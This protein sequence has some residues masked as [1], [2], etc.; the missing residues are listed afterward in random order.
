MVATGEPLL[1]AEALVVGHGGRPILP[2]FDLEV[3]A[4]EL[5]VVIGRNGSGKTTLVRTLLG[6]LPPVAGRVRRLRSDLR[7]AHVPQ[8]LPFDPLFPLSAW[9]VVR[10]GTVRRGRALLVGH[11]ETDV[12]ARALEAVGADALARQSFGALSEGQRQRVL[13]ARALAG[14]PDLLVLDE[15]TGALDEVAEREAVETL[16][17]VRAER[18]MAVVLV[19]HEL[20]IARSAADRVLLVDREG[21]RVLVGTPFELFEHEAFRTSFRPPLPELASNG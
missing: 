18:S 4:G 15:P 19:T 14:R 11:R 5:L 21:G 3:R 2:A 6:L 1:R 13:L 17:S 9:D 8:R 16:R 20:D 10:L 12:V 7:L